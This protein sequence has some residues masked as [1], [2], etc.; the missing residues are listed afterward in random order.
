MVE[1]QELA[2]GVHQAI[3]NRTGW[4]LITSGDSVTIV[5][6]GWPKDYDLIVE[7]LSRIG[8]TP[9]SVQGI[10]LTHGHVDHLGCAEE[11][12]VKHEIDS[13]IHEI[14]APMARGEAH[15]GMKAGYL[16]A[17]LWKPD[18]FRFGMMS[19]GRGALSLTSLAE[20]ETFA[21]AEPLDLP[22][23]PTPVY[24]PGHT[25][26]HCSYHLPDRGVLITGDALVSMEIW[27]ERVEARLMPEEFNFDHTRALASLDRIEPLA[28]DL[29]LTGH[30]P[31]YRGSP[32]KAASE[33][34]E[35]G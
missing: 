8:H 9:A 18:V 20:V 31:P 28:A 10:I 26:G 11:M 25:S 24:T 19:I 14:D 17:R 4:C 7:S 34:R 22:G 29:I 1:I 16:I 2:P 6:A 32:A 13:H 3:A 27:T 23:S 30:G 33:A 35:R 15:E 12:R 21:E 5:D